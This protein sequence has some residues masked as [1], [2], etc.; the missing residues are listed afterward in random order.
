MPVAT[1]STD[2]ETK[3]LKSAPPDGY[4]ELRALPYGKLL[5]RRDRASR[6][7]MLQEA[8]NGRKRRQAQQQEDTKVN[9]ETMQEESRYYEFK[10]CIVDHNLTDPNGRKLDFNNKMDFKMLNPKVGTEIEQ[11]ID[12][13]NQEEDEDDEEDF[14]NAS[15]ESSEVTTLQTSTPDSSKK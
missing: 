4:V 1:V 7:S 15:T 13:L 12:E 9:I 5:Y 8:G 2:T 14:F 10:E 11:Y 3:S 6:M